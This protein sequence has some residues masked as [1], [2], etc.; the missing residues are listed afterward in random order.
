MPPHG[1]ALQPPCRSPNSGKARIVGRQD[2]GCRVLG[3]AF[4]NLHSLRDPGH[5]AGVR[6][7]EVRLLWARPWTKSYASSAPRCASSWF[8]RSRPTWTSGS[9]WVSS[10]GPPREGGS[11]G[12]LGVGYPGGGRRQRRQHPP[13]D[14]RRRRAHPGGRLLR[15]VC[16]ALHPRHRGAAHPGRRRRPCRSSASCGPA[17]A[18]PQ[19]AA[20]AVT[21]PDAGSD[22]ASHQDPRRARRRP[23]R[24]ERREDL[25]HLRPAR[26]LRHHRGPHRGRGHRG[27]SLLVIEKGDSR[28]LG[29]KAPRKDRAGGAPTPRSSPSPTPACR[30][31][32]WSGA[33]GAGFRQIMQHFVSERLCLAVRPTR[34]PSAAWTW[35][36]AGRR[37]RGLRH[38]PRGQAGDPPQARRDGAPDRRGP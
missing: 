5:V 32:T 2:E 1:T 37:A 16:R 12:L 18:G 14:G 23:L 26:R 28:L 9:G 15:P 31:R 11:R 20:L 21:E 27:L 36:S 24:G 35:R 29:G 13:L 19:I 22:V 33:E 30:P 3:S 7:S 25:H 34:R 6:A 38:P 17:L 4:R 8:A 10:S